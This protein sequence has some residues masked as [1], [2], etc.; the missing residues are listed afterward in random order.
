M[1][2]YSHGGNAVFENGKENI[3]DLSAN[4]NPLGI[5]ENVRDAIIQEISNCAFY[6]DSFSGK[7][8]KK[9]AEFEQVNPDWIFC[10]NGTSDIIF[11]LP[12][13]TQAKKVALTAP[14]FLDYKRSSLSFGS[15][16]IQY[17]LSAAN[18][19]ILDIGFLETL[20]MEFPCLVF[21]CNPNN[22]TGGL[23]DLI[24][25]KEL[26]DYCQQRDAWLVVDEC[27]MD[28]SEAADEYS[29]KVFLESHSNLIILKAFT[30]LFALPGIRLGYA[31]CANKTLID[32]FYFHGADWPV[33]NLAQTAGIAALDGAESF[34]KQTVAYVSTERKVIESE[35]TQ[36][37][38]RIFG[39]QANYVFLQNTY[40]FDLCEELDKKG[41][42]I[43]SCKNYSG[44]DNSYFRI[45]VSTK[46]NNSTLLAAIEEIL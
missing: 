5:P 14:T 41:I 6:P 43:R 37:G 44:L 46:E 2:E 30:K 9:I 29:S 19:F 39:S 45:A 10:A 34:I 33:S 4:L 15:E 32:N 1:Y 40:P 38:F 8:R 13:A 3:I 21:V 17:K 25:I 27:F 35:L 26:L 23:T 31:L 16:I 20:R 22:P 7:L 24:L 12:R 28:F 18:G 36:L 42:R 11:R